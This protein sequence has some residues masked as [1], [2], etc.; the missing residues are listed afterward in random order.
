MTTSV[1]AADKIALGWALRPAR[2]AGLLA[3]GFGPRQGRPK[4][5]PWSCQRIVLAFPAAFSWKGGR[6][7]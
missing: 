3:R 2:M 4:G 5:H 6:F 1:L 7:V